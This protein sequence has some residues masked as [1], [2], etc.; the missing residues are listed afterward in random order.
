VRYPPE[1]RAETREAVLKAAARELRAHGFDGV[2]VDRLS[3]AAGV[4]S[5]AFYSHFASKEEVLASVIE[6]NL[7]QPFVEPGDG[8]LAT[9][10]E[11]LR[12]YLRNY[13]SLHHR[14]DP[15]DGCVIPTLSADVARSG[16]AVRTVYQTRMLAFID[17]IAGLL[18]GPPAAREKKAWTLLSL[19]VGA[20]VIARAMPDKAQATRAIDAA[21]ESALESVGE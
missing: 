18:K 17:K 2:G 11:R 3:A 5:G 16:R 10:R 15:G 6:E 4:T 12:A 14:D 13:I 1:R 21:L 20:M 8:D 19:M 7:G 9:R